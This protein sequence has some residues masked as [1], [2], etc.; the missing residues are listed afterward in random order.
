MRGLK[1]QVCVEDLDS[2]EVW[3]GVVAALAP[4]VGIRPYWGYL[5]RRAAARSRLRRPLS[6]DRR[7][8]PR[9]R[10][11]PLRRFQTFQAA[12]PPHCHDSGGCRVPRAPLAQ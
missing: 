1:R 6:V 4:P 8:S 5:R 7:P 2:I 12:V 9:K 10:T 11:L 3:R